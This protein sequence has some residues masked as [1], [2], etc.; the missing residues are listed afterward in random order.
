MIYVRLF[1]PDATLRSGRNFNVDPVQQ[2]RLLAQRSSPATV[3]IS[4]ILGNNRT[5]FVAGK[6]GRESGN[7][8][9][10]GRFA[11]EATICD[12]A[13]RNALRDARAAQDAFRESRKLNKVPSLPFH[14]RPLHFLAIV[15]FFYRLFVSRVPRHCFPSLPLF[16]S[17][18]CVALLVV[19]DK[20]A[21]RDSSPSL[22]CEGKRQSNKKEYLFALCF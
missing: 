18:S 14:A 19:P 11:E 10:E 1:A 2:S 7:R 16:P 22:V 12:A 21:E 20:F 3:I 4:R 13:L 5:S 9:R 15:S 6:R 8:F 17:P